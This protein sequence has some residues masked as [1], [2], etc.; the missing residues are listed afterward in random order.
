MREKPFVS[1][2]R[3]PDINKDRDQLIEELVELRALTAGFL[4]SVPGAFIVLDS[5]WRLVYLNK[6]AKKL[7]D[8]DEASLMGRPLEEIYPRKLGRMLSPG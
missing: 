4:G 6:E 2:N 8:G 7:F 1:L 3:Q 5:Q